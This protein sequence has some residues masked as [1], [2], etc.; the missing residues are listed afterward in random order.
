MA[1][2]TKWDA[3]KERVT[4]GSEDDPDGSLEANLENADPELCVRLLQ[5][6]TIRLV[7]VGTTPCRRRCSS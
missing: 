4:R 3:V 2:R 5:V 1:S 6:G 7:T